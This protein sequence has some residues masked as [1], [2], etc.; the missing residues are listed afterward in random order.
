MRIDYVEISNF[1]QH[2]DRTEQLGP[3]VIGIVGRNGS[4][5]SNLVAAIRRGLTG[6]S[7]NQGTKDEDLSWGADKGYVKV[8]FTVG[9]TEGFIKRSLTS[10]SCN[11]AF[12]DK[13]LKTAAEIEYV[14]YDILGVPAQTLSSM[15]FIKQ[16]EIEG[17]LFDAKADRAKAFQT[18]FGTEQA[19]KLRKV[20]GEEIDS[21]VI[22][23]RT[24]II[25]S[26]KV[27]LAHVRIQL[28][29]LNSGLAIHAPNILA[30]ELFERTQ[31]LVTGYETNMRVHAQL[32]ELTKSMT[33]A[34]ANVAQLNANCDQVAKGIDAMELIRIEQEPSV[35]SSQQQLN[36]YGKLELQIRQRQQ[37]ERQIQEAATALAELPPAPIENW[38]D[39]FAL[40]EKKN[41]LST[42][43]TEM[44]NQWRIMQGEACPTCKQVVRAAAPAA[45]IE[46]CKAK[47]VA[48]LDELNAM[49]AKLVKLQADINAYH[50]AKAGWDQRQKSANDKNADAH[51]RL[52]AMPPEGQLPSAEQV[53]NMQGLIRMYNDEIVTPLESHRR[54]YAAMTASR[55]QW[56]YQ[57]RVLSDRIRE[58]QATMTTSVT[59]DEYNA[60]R[61]AIAIHSTAVNLTADANGK[62]SILN[63]QVTQLTQQI[64]QYEHEEVH[65]AQL[66]DWRDRLERARQLLHREQLP[67]LVAQEFIKALNE[68]LAYYLQ[69]FEVPFLAEI[70]PDLN[71]QCTFSGGHLMQAGRLSGGQKVMLG[72]AFRF[73]VY[74]L[75]V[76]NLGMLILDEPTVYL[77]DG[78]IEQVYNLLMKVRSY[79]KSAGL[80]LIVVTH[81]KRLMEIF[82]KVI[83]I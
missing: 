79:S 31:L 34:D 73:A 17:L 55:D 29:S 80:Q 37:L 24:E 64:A 81:D 44:H 9:T 71:V 61:E 16:G 6:T 48:R 23:S 33:A 28:D 7:G 53:K 82:D 40:Q 78:N 52:Y 57:Q 25:E 42:E 74:D 26:S 72:I 66:K 65:M 51:T 60:A 21:L 56:V 83:E 4:G 19:E 63:G 36:D 77:D 47:Y 58:V 27:Q 12:G 30:P 20:L 59:L 35:K 41:K 75:F 46:E 8:G 13:K 50:V 2:K 54:N 67:N 11:M 62:L 15:V 1:C 38:E 22:G 70:Q 69:L 39:P 45:E 76:A 10:A 43:A 68:R 3:G 18:L 32:D 5:K 14:L 49:A